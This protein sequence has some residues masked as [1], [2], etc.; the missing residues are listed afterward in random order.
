MKILLDNGH[1]IDTPG[2][3]SPMWPDGSQ[4]FEFE[5]NRDIVKRV[6][7]DLRSAGVE[8]VIIVPEEID[9]SLKERVRRVNRI[10]GKEPCLLVSVHAN[11]GGGTGWETFTSRGETKSDAYA[12]KIFNVAEVLLSGWKM[13]K[14][15]CSDGDVDKEADF[16]LLKATIC[17]AVLTENLFMDTERDC[18]FLMSESGR[19]VIA[20]IHTFGILECLKWQ[21]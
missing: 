20:D 1:G 14:D 18:R 16:T 8:V 21:S 7:A 4:L 13:R 17:P 12:T 10:A 3:R 19:K 2:K 6:A 15:T 9:I 11:A 5:F